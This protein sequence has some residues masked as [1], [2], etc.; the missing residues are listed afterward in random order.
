MLSA[1]SPSSGSTS[2][3]ATVTLTGAGYAAG[4][5]ASIGGVPC[6]NVH[7]VN[8]T[9]LTCTT[10]AGAAGAANVVVTVNSQT[11]TLTGGYTYGVRQ[12]AAGAAAARPRRWDA[13]RAAGITP[14]RPHRWPGAEPAARASALRGSSQEAA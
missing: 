13:E 6:T 3:G 7:V 10:G 11:G 14:E 1:I 4:A 2:G 5:A 8:S 9:T 12:P